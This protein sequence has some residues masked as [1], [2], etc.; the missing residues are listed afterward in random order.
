VS[1]PT[2]TH[3]Q[4]VA[5]F[6]SKVEKAD[7][8]WL[9][10]AGLFTTG[11][12]Q[13][14][15]RGR[16]IGAHVFSYT[17]AYGAVP[18]GLE[19]CHTCDSVRHCVNPAHLYAGTEKD[20]ARDRTAQGRSY[21]GDQHPAR[22]R[23][24]RLMRGDAWRRAHAEH[25][26]GIRG[27]KHYSRRRPDLIARGERSGARL[28]PERYPKGDQHHA[29]AKPD[30]LARGEGHGNHKLTEDEVREI[31]A[32]YAA[33]VGPTALGARFSVHPHTAS[34]VARRRA[35]KHIP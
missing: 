22:L 16:P 17:L 21:R 10:T 24:E 4:D 19:V 29:R 34:Q 11:Y 1:R 5:R 31:R 18:D 23:P 30:V 15:L 27:D 33:G 14:H 32:L 20:N 25:I 6:W 12:G 13:F 35:W 28:H 7:G 8:C 3:E 2:P 26:D 9:W